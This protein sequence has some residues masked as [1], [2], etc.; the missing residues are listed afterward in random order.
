MSS[1]SYLTGPAK[2]EWVRRC[3]KKRFKD[4][5]QAVR[6]IKNIGNRSTRD[7]IPVR[8]YACDY[9]GGFHLTKQPEAAG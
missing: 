2:P 6:A 3:T 8:S 9:C 5:A 7:D 4:H 1:G